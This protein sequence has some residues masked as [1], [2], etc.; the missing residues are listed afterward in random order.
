MFEVNNGK[1]LLPWSQRKSKYVHV[2]KGKKGSNK[3]DWTC[4][5]NVHVLCN[6]SEYSG[7]QL[8]SDVEYSRAPDGLAKYIVNECL[9][10]NSWFKK[11]YP[12]EFQNWYEG[13]PEA[14][15]P[16]ELHAVLAHYVSEWLGDSDADVFKSNLDIRSIVKQLYENK[17][18]IAASVKWGNL[19]GHIVTVVGFEATSEEDLKEWLYGF[20]SKLKTV[21]VIKKIIIDDPWGYYD[22]KTDKYDGNKSGNDVRISTKYFWDHMKDIKNNNFKMGH[23]FKKPNHT[24]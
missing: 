22:E 6:C 4:V 2:Q 9:K 1:E 15:T 19:L 7:W 18:A 17:I 11:N 24:V 13:N 12:T 21:D 5:C 16:L 8:P 23:I 3:I 14:Y 20:E 10:P